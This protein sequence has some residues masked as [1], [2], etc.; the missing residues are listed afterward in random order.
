MPP[1]ILIGDAEVEAN[2]LGMADMEIPIRLRRK[3]GDHS[4]VM[5]AGSAIGRDDLADEV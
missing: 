5:F 1:G 3:A 4:S 2:R